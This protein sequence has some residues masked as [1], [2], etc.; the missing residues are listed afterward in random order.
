MKDLNMKSFYRHEVPVNNKKT[1]KLH[2][3][4]GERERERERER[5]FVMALSTS[6]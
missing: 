2:Q 5:E 4:E 6:A 1:A 3:R